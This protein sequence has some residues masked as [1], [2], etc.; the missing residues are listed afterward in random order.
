VG[1]NKRHP[2]CDKCWK[3]KKGDSGGKGVGSLSLIR[4]EIKKKEKEE[5][6]TTWKKEGRGGGKKRQ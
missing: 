6:G 3:G 2:A 5:E 1:G 4:A